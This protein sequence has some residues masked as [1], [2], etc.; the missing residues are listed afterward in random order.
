M[1]FGPVQISNSG[2][3]ANVVCPVCEASGKVTSKKKLSINLEKGIYHCWVC[4]TKG[5]NIA[6]F[7]VRHTSVPKNA[8]ATLN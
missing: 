5:R 8:F 1:C 4:E 7:A 3:N 2:E 6:K